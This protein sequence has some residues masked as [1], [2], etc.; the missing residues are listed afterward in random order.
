MRSGAHEIYVFR[1]NARRVDN[2]FRQFITAAFLPAA[3]NCTIGT[4]QSRSYAAREAR[5]D[6]SEVQ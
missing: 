2:S 6:K 1:V 3:D 5:L 4:G